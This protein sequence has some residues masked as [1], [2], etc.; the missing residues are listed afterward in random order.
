MELKQN[1]F[2][3]LLQNKTNSKKKVTDNKK[4]RSFRKFYL[5]KFMFNLLKNYT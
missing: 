4:Y 2:V 5:K 3:Y 1:I